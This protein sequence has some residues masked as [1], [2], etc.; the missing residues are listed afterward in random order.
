MDNNKAM[1]S[2]LLE[3][4]SDD[5]AEPTIEIRPM[6]E[7]DLPAVALVEH[8]AYPGAL[9][10]G[11]EVLGAHRAVHPEG[12][13]VAAVAG[14]G[15]LAGYILSGPARL[16]DCPLEIENTP[17]S[18]ESWDVPASAQAGT[19]ET[20]YLHDISVRP[21]FRK[22]G[23]GRRLVA[24]VEALAMELGAPT[25]TLTAVAGAWGHW[26][27]LGFVELARKSNAQVSPGGL[28]SEAAVE[29]LKSYPTEAVLM[30]RVA[31]PLAGQPAL[32]APLTAGGRAAAAHRREPSAAQR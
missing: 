25:I 13:M 1:G 5:E 4:A 26:S 24:T 3:L 16:E 18:E 22:F 11:E 29:R 27:R 19:A 12:C 31:N 21:E 30:R 2:H 7:A 8:I 10:E 6:T 9:L 28:L 17:E 32:A 23:L 15:E 20:V 14:T